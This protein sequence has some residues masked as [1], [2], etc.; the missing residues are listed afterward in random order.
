MITNPPH[1]IHLLRT[2][3]KIVSMGKT[4]GMAPPSPRV[5][6]FMFRMML[7]TPLSWN[8]F[9]RTYHLYLQS[10]PFGTAREAWGLLSAE[11]ST[12]QTTQPKQP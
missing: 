4:S 11:Q 9:L 2:Y 7:P 5:V 12:K 8:D 1:I 3:R 6:A 10:I